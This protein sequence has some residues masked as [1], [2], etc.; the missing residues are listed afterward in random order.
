MSVLRAHSKWSTY[1]EYI[2]TNAQIDTKGTWTPLIWNCHCQEV[3][4]WLSN[5]WSESPFE[6]ITTALH[7]IQL[8][9]LSFGV[10]LLDRSVIHLFITSENALI[11]V[12]FQLLLLLLFLLCFWLHVVVLYYTTTTSRTTTTTRMRMKRFI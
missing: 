2:E 4:Y 10:Q 7:C 5:V 1:L 3:N 6:T 9:L 11:S 8:Y 12:N